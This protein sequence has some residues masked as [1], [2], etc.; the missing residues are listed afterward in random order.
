MVADRSACLRASPACSGSRDT[1]DACRCFPPARRRRWR[2]SARSRARC[3]TPALLLQV[4]SGFDARDPGAVAEPVPDFLGACDVPARGLS[5]RMVADAGLRQADAEVLDPR[6]GGG[7]KAFEAMGLQCR[8]G[9]TDLDDPLDQFHG[10][11]FFAGAGTRLRPVL[12]G[13]RELLD[14]RLRAMLDMALAQT[15]KGYYE[16][17]FPPLRLRNQNGRILRQ[18]RLPDYADAARGG[19]RCR[20]RL[21]TGS[22]ERRQHHFM[23]I[24]HLSVQPDRS[25]GG[26][27]AGRFT[28]AGLPVGMQIVGR[29]LGE[30]QILRLAAAFEE[31]RP[32]AGK[33]PPLTSSRKAGVR[34]SAAVARV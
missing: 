25:A 34:L 1:S 23:D 3:A 22:C 17:V 33:R 16:T 14:R 15:M 18:I 21:C 2:M 12:T 19:V 31:A 5:S 4:I 7:E 26:L 24:L 10:R 32:W 20:A 28:R 9:R 6:D 27:C 11:A 8:T 13:R 29:H 30:A